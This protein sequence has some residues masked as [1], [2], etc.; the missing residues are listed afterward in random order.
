MLIITDGQSQ[1]TDNT[2]RKFNLFKD[3]NDID[4]MLSASVEKGIPRNVL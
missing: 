1:V 3:N 2:V 4:G